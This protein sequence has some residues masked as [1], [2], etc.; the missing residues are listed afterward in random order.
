MDFKQLTY[1]LHM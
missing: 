1:G